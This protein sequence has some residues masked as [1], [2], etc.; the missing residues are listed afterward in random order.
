MYTTDM[1]TSNISNDLLLG[2][3]F[4]KCYNSVVNFNNNTLV[5]EIRYFYNSKRSAHASFHLYL[6]HVMRRTVVPSQSAKLLPCYVPNLIDKSEN[7]IFE[8]LSTI[9]PKT[10]DAEILSKR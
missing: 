1:V 9:L 2:Y 6:V 5:L 8:P 10:T 7:I 3:E 4:L